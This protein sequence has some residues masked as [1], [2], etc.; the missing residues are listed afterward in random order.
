MPQYQDFSFDAGTDNLCL[1]Q[2]LEPQDV[3]TW[4]VTFTAW[5]RFGGV[6]PLIQMGL[7]PLSG[8][9]NGTSGITLL[10]SGQ[11]AWQ[12]YFQSLFTSGFQQGNIAYKYSR[13]DSGHH[14]DLAVG[15]LLLEC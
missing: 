5:K 12:L 10:N 9:I 14:V 6:V 4:S 3:S 2:L 8:Q 13:I 11:G 7:T 15:Y 1:V